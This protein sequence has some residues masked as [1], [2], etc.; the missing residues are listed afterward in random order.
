[1]TCYTIISHSPPEV[2]GVTTST[3]ELDTIQPTTEAYTGIIAKVPTEEATGSRPVKI[4]MIV[5][6]LKHNTSLVPMTH[7]SL[8]QRQLACFVY[9]CI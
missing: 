2:L 5:R 6:C 8:G 7:Y 3:Y 9:C 1:M 4:C